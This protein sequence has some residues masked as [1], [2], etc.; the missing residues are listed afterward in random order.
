MS[1]VSGREALAHARR[2]LAQRGWVFEGQA[3]L[4]LGISNQTLAH[5]RGKGLIE[6]IT[7]NGMPRYTEQ[8]L[9]DCREHVEAERNQ[10]KQAP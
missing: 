9:R 1:K 4:L 6:Y 5:W 8:Q 2:T 7:I 10:R 3:A